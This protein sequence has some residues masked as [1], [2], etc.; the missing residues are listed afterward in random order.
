M[1]GSVTLD[2]DPVDRGCSI[3]G[4]LGPRRVRTLIGYLMILIFEVA[5]LHSSNHETE[6]MPE[7]SSHGQP[8]AASHEIIGNFMTKM[9]RLLEATL[10]NRRGER[11]LN[12]SNDEALERFL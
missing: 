6:A 9:T 7:S 12:T 4:G 3:F 1:L 11:A 10:V 8:N 2:L 5:G